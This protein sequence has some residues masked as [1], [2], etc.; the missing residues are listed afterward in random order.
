M[1]ARRCVLFDVVCSVVCSVVI[2]LLHGLLKSEPVGISDRF[3]FLFFV[4]VV[5]P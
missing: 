3:V 1:C 4:E 2:V 5:F